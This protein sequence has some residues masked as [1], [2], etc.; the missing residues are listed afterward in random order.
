MRAR[1]LR[2]IS[3]RRSQQLFK[4]F[5]HNRLREPEYLDVPIEKPRAFRKMAEIVFGNPP[6]PHKLAGDFNIPNSLATAIINAHAERFE[7]VA[8]VQEIDPQ[9]QNIVEFPT[10]TLD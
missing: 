9:F 8:V 10:K 6:D 7:V 5:S 3:E 1:E 4:S 2:I